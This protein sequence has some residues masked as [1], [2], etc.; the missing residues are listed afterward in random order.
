MSVCCECCV[1]SG[2]GL[3]D[4]LITRPEEFYRLW[5]VVVCDLE[6]SRTSR[7]WPALAR[8]ATE[9]RNYL[10][11]VLTAMELVRGQER[12]LGEGNY[13]ITLNCAFPV[14]CIW[15]NKWVCG[16]KNNCICLIRCYIIIRMFIGPC[17]IIIVEEL[18]TNLMSLVIFITLN[19]CSTYFEH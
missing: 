4:E 8:S 17:I 18:E 12:V 19:I 10:Y 3:C 13:T 14:V 9:K 1:L 16:Q 15:T 5:C 7:P 6:T 11:A 2:R